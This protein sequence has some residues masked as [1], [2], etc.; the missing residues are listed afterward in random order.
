[1]GY[2]GIPYTGTFIKYWKNSQNKPPNQA[3]LDIQISH[4]THRRKMNWRY[5]W[6]QSH[7]HYNSVL[8]TLQSQ[9]GMLMHHMEYICTANDRQEQE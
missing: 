7:Y 6:V 1:M 8:T 5:S 2:C 3:Q 9:S 4:L